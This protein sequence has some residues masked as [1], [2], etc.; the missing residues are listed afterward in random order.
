MKFFMIG[1][2]G[3]V[4]IAASTNLA[5]A[6]PKEYKIKMTINET[7]L[8]D[9]VG[10]VSPNNH[11]KLSRSYKCT[12]TVTA[13]PDKS[14]FRRESAPGI[15]TLIGEFFAKEKV[16]FDLNCEQKQSQLS[17]LMLRA[18]YKGTYH[19]TSYDS[20]QT[21]TWQSFGCLMGPDLYSASIKACSDVSYEL[22]VRLSFSGLDGNKE[23]VSLTLEDGIITGFAIKNWTSVLMSGTYQV[24]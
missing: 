15:S 4:A 14:Y 6:Q 8:N 17:Y 1:L 11:S 12:L 5:M 3:F 9:D 19:G 16:A 24:L 10:A 7:E 2:L 18:F 21:H 20:G 22:P 13:S 23:P